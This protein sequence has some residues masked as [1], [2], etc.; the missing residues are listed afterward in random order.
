MEKIVKLTSIGED[1]AYQI[2][3]ACSAIFIHVCLSFEQY[4]L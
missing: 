3:A 2:T 4:V 1:M